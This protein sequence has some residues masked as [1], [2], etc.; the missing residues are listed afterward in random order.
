M[1]LHRSY[2]LT[3]DEEACNSAQIWLTLKNT[4]TGNNFCKSSLRSNLN[5]NILAFPNKYIQNTN[6]IKGGLKMRKKKYL[7]YVG[8]LL[9]NEQ[10]EQL[11]NITD[12]LEVTISKYVRGLLV[13]KLKEKD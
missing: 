13:K 3:P 1:A 8:V 9:T 11:I 7:K 10:Y 2:T 5:S 6:Y 12:K 4:M